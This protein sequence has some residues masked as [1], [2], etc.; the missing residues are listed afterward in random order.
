MRR[1]VRQQTQTRLYLGPLADAVRLWSA[2]IIRKAN[3]RDL[4]EL[5]IA[6]WMAFIKDHPSLL[7]LHQVNA[8]GYGPIGSMKIAKGLSDIVGLP[9]YFHIGEFQGTT[10]QQ[11]LADAAFSIA[12]KGRLHHPH[13]S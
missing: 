4:G 11:P 7:E 9:L 6:K 1:P 12:E 10:P 5:S 3:P 13:L 8:H 2:S